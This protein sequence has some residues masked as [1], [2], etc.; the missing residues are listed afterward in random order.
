MRQKYWWIPRCHTV[1]TFQLLLPLEGMGERERTCVASTYVVKDQTP[2]ER[3]ETNEHR[4]KGRNTL[5]LKKWI[6][7][8]RKHPY[9]TKA[10]K[11]Y[12]AS[13]ANM[14]VLQVENWF[15]NVRRVI[16]TIT[17]EVWLEK[18]PT[19]CADPYIQSVHG[20]HLSCCFVP[21]T[22][23]IMVASSQCMCL[24]YIWLFFFIFRYLISPADN[25]P[26]GGQ[27]ATMHTTTPAFHAPYC[28]TNQATVNGINFP[29]THISFP[30]HA[31]VS[32]ERVTTCAPSDQCALV[33]A[34]NAP[35]VGYQQQF[36]NYAFSCY[37][38]LH[39]R[40]HTLGSMEYPSLG[41][42]AHST[43]MVNRYGTTH[44]PSHPPNALRPLKLVDLTQKMLTMPSSSFYEFS[45]PSVIN[46]SG[47][48]SCAADVPLQL[49]STWENGPR[50]D[51]RLQQLPS[52]P[53]QSVKEEARNGVEPT[54][55]RSAVSWTSHQMPQLICEW[56]M[57]RLEN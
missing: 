4:K 32:S 31:D 26:D 38:D 10:E 9:P 35:S 21:H 2:R 39:N 20:K 53:S 11:S 5:I 13:Q 1:A 55:M 36:N 42:G 33:P 57:M 49:L 12:L 45:G 25:F 52:I 14:T 27:I 41:G 23:L 51:G 28:I 46:T 22:V 37:D 16:K 34:S 17:F 44:L 50:T 30:P 6:T 29:H 24:V 8:H 56:L 54:Y 7:T 18:H 48:S 15:A 40:S 3:E 19:Y 47:H 43:E